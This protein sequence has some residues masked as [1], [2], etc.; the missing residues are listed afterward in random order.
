MRP[1]TAVVEGETVY[2]YKTIGS[3]IDVARELST[4]GA[5]GIVVAETQISGKGRYGRTWVSLPGGLYLSWII[6]R[7][8]ERQRNLREMTAVAAVRTLTSFG[9][10]GC[11][12]KLPNDILIHDNKKIA[13]IL[14]EQNTNH[15]IISIG[16]NVNN[17]GREAGDRAASVRDVL[18][19]PVNLDDFLAAFIREFRR[20]CDGHPGTVRS[21][22]EEW[23]SLLIK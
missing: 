22:R 7:M 5:S 19:G 18:G 21:W 6:P 1:E 23:S 13:G 3:T 8:P 16:V 14:I 12:I 10:K 11:G 2:R 17:N 4:K 9:L 20:A 15:C